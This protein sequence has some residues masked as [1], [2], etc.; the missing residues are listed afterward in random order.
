V[1]KFEHL[2]KE[3]ERRNNPKIATLDEFHHTQAELAQHVYYL[4][5]TGRIDPSKITV[6]GDC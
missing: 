2:I 5:K 3:Y 4:C 6:R 1:T